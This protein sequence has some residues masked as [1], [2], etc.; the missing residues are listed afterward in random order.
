MIVT[1]LVKIPIILLTIS[2]D[3]PTP[4]HTVMVVVA[5][6]LA[7]RDNVH[8]KILQRSIYIR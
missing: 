3:A 4:T 2:V 1:Q 6:V 7:G 5:N 8:I